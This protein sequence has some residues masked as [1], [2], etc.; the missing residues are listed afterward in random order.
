[1]RLHTNILYVANTL[2]IFQKFFQQQNDPKITDGLSILLW[3]RAIIREC[4]GCDGGVA[5]IIFVFDTVS[6]CGGVFKSHNLYL[7]TKIFFVSF[8][9]FAV[10]STLLSLC[11]HHT[12]TLCKRNL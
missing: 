4:G 2:Y 9:Q 8:I 10:N 12:H 6:V 3:L 5:V 7:F 11:G 1:M